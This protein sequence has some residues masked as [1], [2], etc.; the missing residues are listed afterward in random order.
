MHEREGQDRNVTFSKVEVFQTLNIQT[1]KL[2]TLAFIITQVHLTQTCV[3]GQNCSGAG[4][5]E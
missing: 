2:G 3:W 1:I 4:C 5:V